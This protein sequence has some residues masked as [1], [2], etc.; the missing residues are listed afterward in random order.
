MGQKATLAASKMPGC[1]GQRMFVFYATPHRR[2]AF[3]AS[4][5]QY[6]PTVGSFQFSAFE[7][8]P[9]ILRTIGL[10]FVGPTA[11]S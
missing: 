7:I 1:V 10:P 9:G 6:D 4:H 5:Y 2:F 8:H 11:V 3:G